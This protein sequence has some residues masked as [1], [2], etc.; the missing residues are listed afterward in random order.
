MRS[1]LSVTLASIDF[2]KLIS[3]KDILRT[4]FTKN[5]EQVKLKLKK[6]FS[7]KVDAQKTFLV[8]ATG[9]KNEFA[10]LFQTFAKSLGF[11]F[12]YIEAELNR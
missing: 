2:R 7:K 8:S 9:N 1:I 11:I 5:L 3:Y 6:L 10:L 12:R 4:C